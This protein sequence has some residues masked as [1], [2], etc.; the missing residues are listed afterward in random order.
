MEMRHERK[1]LTIFTVLPTTELCSTVSFIDMEM[2]SGGGMSNVCIQLISKNV[3]EIIDL[4]KNRASEQGLITEL[5]ASWG[6]SVS[7]IL[8]ILLKKEVIQWYVYFP[9]LG[10]QLDD[11][12]FLLVFLFAQESNG[13][14]A[15]LYNETHP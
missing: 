3:S 13:K 5:L 10:K 12:I 1:G 14:F 8:S 15:N 11:S 9:A 7:K 6:L 4:Y 2:P